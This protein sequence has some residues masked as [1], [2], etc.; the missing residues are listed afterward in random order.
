MSTNLPPKATFTAQWATAF[1]LC[2]LCKESTPATEFVR[3]K[4]RNSS[5]VCETCWH[6]RKEEAIDYLAP[7]IER[8]KEQRKQKN[9]FLQALARRRFQKRGEINGMTTEEYAIKA[10]K[11]PDRA[12]AIVGKTYAEQGDAAVLADDEALMMI[13]DLLNELDETLIPRNAKKRLS[14]RG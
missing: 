4:G 7:V 11:L 9:N 14:R 13:R 2:E 6:T 8:T 12:A 1:K 5:R 3:Y 10:A